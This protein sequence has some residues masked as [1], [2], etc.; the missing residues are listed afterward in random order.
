LLVSPAGDGH[1]VVAY[2]PRA[3][4]AYIECAQSC[5]EPVTRR[6]IKP[7]ELS[8]LHR[9]TGG[10]PIAVSHEARAAMLE[11]E[12]LL[13]ALE[14]HVSSTAMKLMD[15]LESGVTFGDGGEQVGPLLSELRHAICDCAMVDARALP[16]ALQSCVRRALQISAEEGGDCQVY[17]W[18]LGET[19][20]WG[21]RLPSV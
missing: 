12:A 4:R 20:Q 18:L 11:H 21:E 2:D 8:R 10:A 1:I 14:R 16:Y 13:V 7:V 9:A 17:L 19:M 15:L 3:L 6:L 5:Q